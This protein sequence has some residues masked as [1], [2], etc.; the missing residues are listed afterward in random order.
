MRVNGSLS[1]SSGLDPGLVWSSEDGT[2]AG[3]A[4]DDDGASIVDVEIVVFSPSKFRK[5]SVMSGSW[6]GPLVAGTFVGCGV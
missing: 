3:K 4:V 6:R 5:E 1:R 2:A